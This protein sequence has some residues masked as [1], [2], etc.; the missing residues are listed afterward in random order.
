MDRRSPSPKKRSPERKPDE[1]KS[2]D[3]GAPSDRDRRFAGSLRKN[4]PDREEKR[5]QSPPRRGRSPS[6]RDEPKQSADKGGNKTERN[7]KQAQIEELLK[8][9][10]A[11]QYLPP[12]KLRMLEEAVQDKE[13]EQYQRL[14]WDALKKSIN[15]LI[16]K[17]RHCDVVLQC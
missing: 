7:E 8:A 6:P 13:S 14:T 17:V 4:L 15:G 12:H 11:G 16:N 1:G 5:S 9:R 3:R 10:G 2:R